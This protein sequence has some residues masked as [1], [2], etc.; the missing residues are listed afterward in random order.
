MISCFFFLHVL[1]AYISLK[2]EIRET[3]VGYVAFLFC[4]FLF[5][6]PPVT[7]S[8]CSFLFVAN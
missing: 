7:F 5:G 3:P 8:L 2:K 1:D 6:A 4:S